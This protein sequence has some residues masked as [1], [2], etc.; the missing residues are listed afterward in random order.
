MRQA[1]LLREDGVIEALNGETEFSHAPDW[2]EWE[3]QQVREQLKR[4]EYAFSDDVDVYFLPRCWKFEHL[5]PAK[6]THDPEN[7]FV[8]EGHYNGQDYR[9][10]R[11]PGSM[12]SLHLEYD[13]CYI[14]PFDCFDVSTEKD[15]FYCYPT[16]ENVVTKLGF[17]V[18]EIYK[19]EMAKK[20]AR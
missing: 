19:M 15:S 14:K 4:G 1:L 18:E 2:F 9:V 11:L 20:A 3:R 6:V 10:Q 8:I 13:Y 12:N 7:G 5:G 17:A 16:K